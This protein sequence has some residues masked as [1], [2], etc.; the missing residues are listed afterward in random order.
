M[1]RI[2]AEAA[3]IG[4][5]LID[6]QAYWR[7][8]DML[9]AEDFASDTN[10]AIFCA[11]ADLSRK[12]V[13]PDFVTVGEHLPSVPVQDLAA[14]A[15]GTPGASNVRGY[16]EWI[17]QASTERKV[18]SAGQRIAKLRGADAVGEAQ[19][20]IGACVPRMAGAIKR[21]GEFL[22]ESVLRMQ[23]RVDST[24]ALS[25][26]PSG[27]EP[28]DAMTAGW[29]RGDLVILAA[30]PSVGKTAFAL[31]C[32]L[33]A[34]QAE[35]PVLFMSLEMTGSQLTDRALSHLGG[36]SSVAIREP[37][38]MDESGWLRVTNAGAILDKLPLL[39]D[40]SSALTVDSICARVRQ[41]NATTRLGLVV[42]DYLTQIT[43]PR[44]ESMTEAIQAITR[45][46]KAL[47]K[48]LQVPVIL[49]SQLNREGESKPSLSSLRSSG[50]IEQDADVVA[51]LH[52]P[53]PNNRE[54]VQFIVEKQ[55]NGPTGDFYLAAQMD[56][57]RF[58]PCDYAPPVAES[59][60]FGRYKS[61]SVA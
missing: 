40:E 38:R 2:D 30:R 41:C 24:D 9:A 19:R 21:A 12:G 46:L 61:R 42:I 32:A 52:R 6:P 29:Q 23:S 8:A 39:I 11:I 20:I 48:E 18:Q 22:R 1:S 45:Q 54:V 36:V 51:F 4:G 37:K 31:Q 53:D 25:G 56:L 59:R 55:R 7:V 57:M 15:N 50:A 33:H 49:L 13:A 60:G 3:V 28:L 10:R 5:C 27:C 47:A 34:A 16:A 17:V 35:H 43:P 14:L 26:V 44:A 58:D